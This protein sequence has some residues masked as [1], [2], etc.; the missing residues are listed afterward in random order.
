MCMNLFDKHASVI[1]SAAPI[2]MQAEEIKASAE[3][4]QAMNYMRTQKHVGRIDE[5]PT[6]GNGYKVVVKR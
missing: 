5:L 4:K 2:L 1:E 6:K 3:F